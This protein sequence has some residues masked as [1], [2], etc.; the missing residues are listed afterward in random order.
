MSCWECESIATD[1]VT[2]ILTISARRAGPLLL[3]RACY[4]AC[5]LPLASHLAGPETPVHPLLLAEPG[6]IGHHIGHGWT[7]SR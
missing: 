5:Y 1:P 7:P 6:A 4:A 3:C 2:V